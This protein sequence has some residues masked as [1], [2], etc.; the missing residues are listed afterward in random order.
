MM[1]GLHG[2]SGHNAQLRVEVEPSS[3]V[4]LVMTPAIRALDHRFRHA[5]AVWENV[6][7]EVQVQHCMRFIARVRLYE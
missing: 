2:Q 3:G 4:A 5:S 1:A 6:T 7:E